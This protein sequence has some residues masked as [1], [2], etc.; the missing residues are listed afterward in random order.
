MKK[1][2]TITL[3]IF[4]LFTSI[5]ISLAQSSEQSRTNP[6]LDKMRTLYEYP[7]M[8]YRPETRWWLAQGSH[9]D[10]TLLESLQEIKDNGFGGVEFVTLDEDSLDPDRYAWGSEEWIHDSQFIIKQATDLGL[11]V[12]FTNGTHW[13]TANLIGITPDDESASQELG[14]KSL[15]LKAGESFAGSIPKPELPDGVT[16]ANL[17]RVTTAKLTDKAGKLNN[18]ALTD[19]TNLAVETDKG[20]TIEW[21]APSD[22]NYEMFF[23]WSY[24]TGQTNEPAV[25]PAYTINY[26]SKEG[27]HA[28]IDYWDK[29]VFTKELIQE[30]K[31]N[32][33]VNMF[34]DSIEKHTT[35]RSSTQQF[36]TTDFLDEFKNRRGY[37]LTKYLPLIIVKE[38]KGFTAT[39]ISYQYDIEG[40]SEL[41]KKIRNDLGQTYTEL[42][43]E[44]FLDV[45]KKWLNDIGISLRG[46]SSYGQYLEI[47]EPIK[48][49]DYAETESF[50]FGSEIEAYRTM[51]GAAQLY[52]KVFSS[53]TGASYINYTFDYNHFLQIINA[54]FASG[55]ARTVFHGY[56][57]Q[58]GPAGQVEWPGYEGM[59][60]Y[61]SGRFNNRQPA[62]RDYKE[63]NTHIA[64]LQKILQQGSPRVDIGI[65]RTDYFANA[66]WAQRT[67]DYT[68]NF[69]R[70]N[71]G[72]Y[73]Q[74]MTLQNTGYTYNYFSPGILTDK[75]IDYKNGVVQPDGPG[76]QALILYQEEL[77]YESAEVIYEWA[78]EGLPVVIVDGEIQELTR[79]EHTVTHNGAGLRTPFKDGKD[80]KLVEVMANLKELNNVAV[81]NSGE[82]A[83]AALRD[84]G[85]NPR[86]EYADANKKLLSFMRE[87]DDAKYLYVYNYMYSDKEAYSTQISIDGVYKPYLIDTW[88]GDVKEIGKYKI[89]EGKT[90][91]DITLAPGETAVFA[92]DPNV[93]DEGFVTDSNVDEVTIVDGKVNLMVT[94]S[95]NYY[96][97]LSNGKKFEK[98]LKVPENISLTNWNL[99]VE[100]WQP[101]DRVTRKEDRGLG[102][103]TVEEY[104]ET[105]KP[106]I[107]VGLTKLIPWKEIEKVGKS[108]SGIGSYTTSFTIPTNWNKHNGVYLKL[109]SL[110]GGTASLYVNGDK[111]GAID[112]TNPGIDISKLIVKGKNT[113]EIKVTSNLNNRLWGFLPAQEYGLTGEATLITY[114][115]FE[116]P[117]DV[118]KDNKS[119]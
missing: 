24:G 68:N 55:I 66:S 79:P 102:Y 78:K 60:K 91:V 77:Q 59:W 101:G 49:L 46:Q 57:S 100:D 114:E 71:K 27:A 80:E 14:F 44:E 42:Y 25:E 109:G 111:A 112:I 33:N 58:A 61:I 26:Y 116:L 74:D 16:K 85:V 118:L 34:M 64:R 94:K 31:K 29:N 96:A 21:T 28:L 99:V 69:F 51:A 89:E 104:F 9:T 92:L 73:W 5:P 65:L 103:I 35:G 19:I 70:N 90:V 113:L 30:I 95:G 50:T 17:V 39:D 67:R 52:N 88:T 18:E 7:E 81:V 75:N 105:N 20:W 45:L 84:L 115:K 32:G 6:F 15:E 117:T 47:S 11:G 110:N 4:L 36:W 107:N 108:V 23:F 8:R 98:Q 48:S 12:S 53:E 10:E 72:M 82:A 43:M 83:K 54:Q 41:S 13:G 62:S 63:I 3:C 76:Y 38:G 87:S 2:V 22:G 86:A 40:Q 1:V 93:Q 37:D 119:K 56:S 106:L 97:H